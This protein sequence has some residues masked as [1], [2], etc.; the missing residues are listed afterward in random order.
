MARWEPK[1]KDPVGPNERVGRRLFQRRP[2]KGAKDQK[3]PEGTYEISHFEERRE[4]G[5]VSLDRLG[6]TGVDNKVK[7]FVEPQAR[8]AASALRPPGVFEGWA[9]AK[10]TDLENSAPGRRSFK[11][12]PSPVNA[13]PEKNVVANSYHAH[14][15]RPREGE[16]VFS[17]Y[18]TAVILKAIF[19][20]NYHR[21]SASAEKQPSETAWQKL[22]RWFAELF[23]T[24]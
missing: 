14:V 10:A 17:C 13:D 23:A 9:V 3:P 5:E 18:E 22:W 1:P 2:L 8:A 7:N 6:R 21:E 19:E 12:I 20:Q 4:P 11:I 24:R 16:Y 15:E